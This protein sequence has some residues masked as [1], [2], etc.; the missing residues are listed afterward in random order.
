MNRAEKV[1]LTKSLK[2]KFQKA[3]LAIFANYKGL[4]ATQADEFRKQIR[5][6]QGEV[7][8]VKNNLL[9][10][11]AKEGGMSSEVQKVMDAVVGPT[12]VT[13][14]YGDIV[15]A[16]KKISEFAKGNEAFQ[17]RDSLMGDKV[18]L[19]AEVEQL[20]SLP[21]REQLLSMLLSTMQGPARGFVSVLAALPRG[22]VTVLSAIERK[23]SEAGDA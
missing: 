6:I 10:F 9:H 3:D 21:S 7:K 22:L 5:S 17:L 4:K 19:A 16:A 1:E 18:L 13:F 23:K 12:V 14:V 11:A 2:E 20:A 15:T 8:I